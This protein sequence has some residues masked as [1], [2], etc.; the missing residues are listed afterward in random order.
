M[1]RTITEMPDEK[2]RGNRKYKWDEWFTEV[3]EKMA[4]DKGTP[5]QVKAGEADFDCLPT[6][7]AVSA[8]EAAKERGFS[9]H[10]PGIDEDSTTVSVE[11]RALSTDEADEASD[12]S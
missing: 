1:P 2:P 4:F 8:R 12:E 3:G 6:S 5:E 9:L 10:I 11:V 7:F